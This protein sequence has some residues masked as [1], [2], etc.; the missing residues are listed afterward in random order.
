[1][2]F[3]TGKDLCGISVSKYQGILFATCGVYFVD[4]VFLSN[5][6][7]HFSRFHS[8][9]E[10]ICT[11]T[12]NTRNTCQTLKFQ[13]QQRVTPFFLLHAQHSPCAAH[14]RSWGCAGAKCLGLVVFS[15]EAM[16]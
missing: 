7:K 14:E 10:V 5:L 12:D 11:R 16:C 3:I 2:G 8:M 15:W 13:F 4:A 9:M 1:M 6:F